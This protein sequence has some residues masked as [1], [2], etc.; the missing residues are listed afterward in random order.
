LIGLTVASGQTLH[1]RGRQETLTSA[2][3]SL[4]QTSK[5]CGAEDIQNGLRVRS[6]ADGTRAVFRRERDGFQGEAHLPW[7]VEVGESLVGLIVG[8]VGGEAPQP[9]PE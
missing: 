4:N 8:K 1:I 7:A 9:R 3:P 6:Q 5:T 2:S